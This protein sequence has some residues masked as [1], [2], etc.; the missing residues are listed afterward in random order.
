MR[1]VNAWL[2]AVLWIFLVFLP[3][4]QAQTTRCENAKPYPHCSK[5]HCNQ[6]DIANSIYETCN[7]NGWGA[8]VWVTTREPVGS[9]HC[10]TCCCSCLAYATLIAVDGDRWKRIET[11]REGETVLVVSGDKTTRKW[12]PRK[13]GHSRGTTPASHDYTI[14]VRFDGKTLTSNP[15]HLYLTIDVQSGEEKLI[16]ADRLSV[17][18]HKL[19]SS[20]FKPVP[21]TSIMHGNFTGGLWG[22]GTDRSDTSVNAHL[23]NTAGVISG[24]Y[25]LQMTYEREHKRAF[26]GLPQVGSPEYYKDNPDYMADSATWQPITGQDLNFIPAGT[27]K[28]PPAFVRFLPEWMETAQPGML[29]P[30]DDTVT[31]AKTRQIEALFKGFYEDITFDLDWNNNTVNAIAFQDSNG[32]KHVRMYGGL[33]RHVAIRK[34]GLAL[35]Y[36]HEVG[37]HYGG[38]PRYPE[39][40]ASCE[41]QADYW[42]AKTSMRRV[43]PEDE[44]MDVMFPAIDQLHDLF[45][46]GLL[47]TLSPEAQKAYHANLCSHPPA[48]CRR[49]TYLAGVDFAPKPSCAGSP[50]GDCD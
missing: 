21:I 42:G 32:R 29:K 27:M 3:H 1:C 13:V 19:V 35:V 23:I 26:M 40:W 11:V 20:D 31:L 17:K 6:Q 14:R 50:S 30:L 38:C 9:R 46:K 43:Y 37:H 25:F 2:G 48:D 44:Y 28:P 24:D 36:A 33:A 41:G 4:S 34:E 39:S 8:D 45:S 5:Q 18:K 47:I 15:N 7:D 10:C 12:I 16:R 22:I 49:D